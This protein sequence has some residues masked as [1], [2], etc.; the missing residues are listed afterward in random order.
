M[1]GGATPSPPRDILFRSHPG[2]I[3]SPL[4]DKK[5]EISVC[6]EA[7]RKPKDDFPSDDE[8]GTSVMS[9]SEEDSENEDN[10]FHRNDNHSCP[11]SLDDNVGQM[12]AEDASSVPTG[13]EQQQ[14]MV[15]LNI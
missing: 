6:A 12:N 14:G 7:R 8:T 10:A 1:Q 3:A 9:S 4:S 2:A 11:S 13:E 5:M 15:F